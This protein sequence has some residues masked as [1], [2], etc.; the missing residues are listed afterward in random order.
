MP[1]KTFRYASC[2]LFAWMAFGQTSTDKTFYLSHTDTHGLQQIANVVRGTGDIRDLSVD[3]AKS[4]IAVHGT[5]EQISMAGWLVSELDKIPAP[6]TGFA[7]HDYPETISGG[8]LMHV[9]FM[10]G[11]QTPSDLQE[12]S[13]AVRSVADIR[14]F[15]PYAPL[16]AI[17]AR[18]TPDQSSLTDWMLGELNGPGK[19]G[20]QVS[21]P[22]TDPGSHRN[23]IAQVFFLANTQTP[24]AV[25]EI[26]NSTRSIS[27]IQRVFPYNAEHALAIRGSAD[28]MALAD[29]LLKELDKPAAQTTSDSD[30]HE[31]QVPASVYRGTAVARVFYLGGAPHP[32]ALQALA[33]AVRAATNIQ[34]AYPIHQVNA[35]AVVGTGDQ[36]ARAEQ[37]VN[38]RDQ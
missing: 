15:L 6:A 14:R 31:Y 7:T 12:I 24:Q 30:S 37:I 13:N 10:S 35:L 2:A 1:G 3:E 21:R 11:P 9:Y 5:A 33:N 34:R 29:W 38:Q 20:T 22:Y 18:G 26:I 36:V 4:A 32:Q 19:P 28:Q 27:D 23:E 17:V 8:D 16:R 25:Q